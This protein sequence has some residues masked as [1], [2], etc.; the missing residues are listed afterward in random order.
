MSAL[1]HV[2]LESNVNDEFCKH[3]DLHILTLADKYDKQQ[4][5]YS[6]NTTLNSAK[7]N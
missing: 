7:H 1:W 5:F 3:W 4:R 2:N 6:A